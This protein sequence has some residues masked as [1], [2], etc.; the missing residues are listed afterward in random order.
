MKDGI[1][2]V[3]FSSNSQGFGEGAVVVKNN[4][5]NGGDFACTY[6]GT[7]N[8]DSVTLKVD[9]HDKSRTSVFGSVGSFSL[10]LKS[11]E[12]TSG[13]YNL[14]GHVEGMPQNSIGIQAK[15][16]GDLLN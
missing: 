8:G 6:R 5:V 1:Y 9:V 10:I 15:H 13:G 2:Y 12:T 11:S 14:S 4:I 3:R 16:I 7:I